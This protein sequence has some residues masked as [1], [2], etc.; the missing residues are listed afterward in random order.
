MRNTVPGGFPVQN[1]R[2]QGT[3]VA[4]GIIRE[5]IKGSAGG[6]AALV[7]HIP[8]YVCAELKQQWDQPQTEVRSMGTEP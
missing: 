7:R 1:Q 3:E 5:I 8:S 4:G 2:V 6:A